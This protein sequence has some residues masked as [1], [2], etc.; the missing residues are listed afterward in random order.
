MERIN[1]PKEICVVR[2]S[3]LGDVV[4]TV[5]LIHNL[6]RAFPEAKITWVI[7]KEFYPIV[8]GL[9]GVEFIVINKPNSLSDYMQLRKLFSDKHYDVLLAMQANLRVNML[10]KAI[11]ATRKIGFDNHRARDLHRWFIKEQIAFKPQHLL[12]GFLEFLTPLGVEE[13]IIE[14]RLPISAEDFK[15]AHEQLP[16]DRVMVLH[17]MAS[18]P[19]R[20]WS[21]ENYSQLIERAH[22][23]MNFSIIVTGGPSATEK[24]LTDKILANVSVPVLNLVGKSSLKQLAA[25]LSCANV[26]VCPD[27][28]PG[29]MAT[30]MGTPV[31]GL[32]A[33]AR[34]ELTGPYF[35]FDLTV[36]KY[37]Q[38]VR[39]F[40]HKDISQVDWHQ[41]VHHAKAMSLITVEDV[42]EKLEKI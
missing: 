4:L 13:K 36:N 30:A 8:E 31:I 6:Q 9:P 42:L 19:E 35:S 12:D 29:H 40:L 2:L 33:V 34:P 28:G 25:L 38:A 17:P 15:W 10:Y 20:N 11:K 23:E 26:V 7:A 3:A 32:Y 16:S 5:P 14:W 41:R 27:T 37:P 1:P 18:K 21:I 39:Q 24:E 22:R